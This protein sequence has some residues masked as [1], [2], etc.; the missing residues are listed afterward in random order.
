MVTCDSFH[1][2]RDLV[3]IKK[4]NREQGKSRD[5]MLNMDDNLGHIGEHRGKEGRSKLGKGGDW[6]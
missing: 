6:M 4:K 2:L 3:S 5:T 1:D